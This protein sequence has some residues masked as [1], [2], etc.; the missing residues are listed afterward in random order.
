MTAQLKTAGE[1]L[2]AIRAFCSP[3]RNDFSQKTD[4]S[5]S[6]LKSWENGV[7]PLSRKGA[8]ALASIFTNKFSVCCTAEWLLD[9]KGPSPLRSPDEL[10]SSALPEDAFVNRELDNLRRYYGDRHYVYKVSDSSMSPFFKI[11]DRIFGVLIE[12]ADLSYFCDEVVLVDVEGY[13]LLLRRLLKGSRPGYFSLSTLNTTDRHFQNPLE[14]VKIKAAYRVMWHRV[15]L[16]PVPEQR[17]V[18]SL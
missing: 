3:S 11:H 1:R 15:F 10:V 9:G 14:D 6:T 5:E 17:Q 12:P 2:R 16:D 8:N 7:A 4:V 18:A 13:G